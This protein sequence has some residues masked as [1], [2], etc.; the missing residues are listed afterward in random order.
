M[1]RNEHLQWC[2]DRAM[3]Y[4]ERGDLENAFSSMV[5]DVKKHPELETHCGISLGMSLKMGS[6]LDSKHEIVKWIEGFN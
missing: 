1:D 5:S 4:V 2:K 6:F 3:E